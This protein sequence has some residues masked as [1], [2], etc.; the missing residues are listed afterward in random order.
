MLHQLTCL[1]CKQ[2]FALKTSKAKAEKRKYCSSNCANQAFKVQ[3]SGEKNP[4]FGKVYRTKATHPEWAAKMSVT[5][6]TRHINAGDKNGMKRPEVAKRMSKTRREKVTS[7][8][9]YRKATSDRIR[10]AWAD[11]K[12]DGV[13]VGQCKWYE[14]M[15]SNG[16]VVKLQGTWEVVFAQFLDSLGVEYSAHQGRIP[17]IDGVGVKRSYYPDFYIPMWDAYVDVKGA[18]F[19]DMHLV[20]MKQVQDSNPEKFIVIV[21]REYFDSIGL[22]VINLSAEYTKSTNKGK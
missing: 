4:A 10:K 2:L 11:G 14:H 17:Y 21:T 5:S 9:T 16:V 19:Y 1:Q 3:F 7:D 8:P 20:K 15:K 12:Y 6:S 18:M 22:N 13:R